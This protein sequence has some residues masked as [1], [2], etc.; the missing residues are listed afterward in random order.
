M[1]KSWSSKFDSFKRSLRFFWQ[2][3][4]R[5]F[6]DGETW[7][8]DYSLAKLIHPRLVRFKLCY[9]NTCE[10]DKEYQDKLD[11]M[12]EAFRFLES[13]ERWSCSPNKAKWQ[14]VQEGLDLF[15]KHYTGLWW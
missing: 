2:R 11:K 9:L 13:E 5:G 14:E 15:A 1:S 6:D 10:T 3:K 4:T 12:I 8:L 7:S